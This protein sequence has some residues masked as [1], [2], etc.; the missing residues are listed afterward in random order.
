MQCTLGNERLSNCFE[1]QLDLNATFPKV[2]Y[3]AAFLLKYQNGHF[4]IVKA[5]SIILSKASYNPVESF[6]LQ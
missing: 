6:K 3:S 2:N 5:V 4:L 1:C